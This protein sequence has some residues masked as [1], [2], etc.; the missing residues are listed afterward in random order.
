MTTPGSIGYLE[1]GYAHSQNLHMATLENKSGNYVAAATDSAKAALASA[2]LPADFILWVSDPDA[3]DAYPIVTYTWMI[4]HKKYDDKD[5]LAAIKGLVTYGLTEGQ[6]SSE[7]LGYVPL[8]D[9]VSS[10]ARAAVD[11][12]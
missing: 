12:L 3:K 4:L 2:Q 5:K 11:A 1:Y 10:K 6:K 9:D 8:P 7:A